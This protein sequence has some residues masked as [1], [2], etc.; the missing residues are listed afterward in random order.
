MVMREAQ[1]FISSSHP[2]S[3]SSHLSPLISH[4]I[5][6]MKRTRPTTA[7]S[8]KGS[9]KPRRSSRVGLQKYGPF[10]N[11][12]TTDPEIITV[13]VN[14]RDEAFHYDAKTSRLNLVQEVWEHEIIP[15]LNVKELAMLRP[16]CKWCD[17]QWQ[18]FLKRNTFRVPEEVP[19]IDEAMRVGF[20]LAKQKFYSKKKS[21][22]VVLS[23]GEHVVEGSWT[24]SNGTVLQ[25]TLGIT[26]SNISFIGQSKDKTT[27]HGGFGVLNKK[28]V[29]L[30]SLTLTSPNGEA[31]LG[32]EGEEAS[33][34]MMGMSVKE[35][36]RHGLIVGSGA[37]VKTTQC[38]FSE[39]GRSGVYVSGSTT[40]ACLTNCTSHH[41]KLD[42]VTA[43]SGAVVD[44]M[45]E[46][47]S[48]HDNE[49]YGLCAFQH[50]ATINV[51]QPCVLNDMSHGNKDQNIYMGSGGIVRQFEGKLKVECAL[52]YLAKVKH[53]FQDDPENPHIYNLFL[54]IMKNFGSQQID[55]PGVISQVSQL[56]RGHNHLILGFNTFLPP[57]QKISKEQ[58]RKMNALHKQLG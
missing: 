58:L 15:F 43:R 55:T 11:G 28:N 42:G 2:S 9:K 22:V 37:S 29:T 31:G 39:N 35:C 49:R 41:N 45:G 6:I 18:E 33:V 57:D 20:N 26:C 52:A 12:T 48:V 19:T 14:N 3:S 44:L 21:L 34:E 50:G 46:G 5:K 40:T 1:F 56:F 8:S 38:E 32:V 10:W 53:E 27:V 51:Y 24:N 23:E 54:D 47:T 13:L 36:S 7:A 4:F 30:K 17:K 25:N 16:T